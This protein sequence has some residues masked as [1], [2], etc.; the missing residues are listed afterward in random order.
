MPRE[1]VSPVSD[2]VAPRVDAGPRPAANPES[3]VIRS[4][5]NRRLKAFRAALRGSGPAAGEPIAIEGPKLV[6][7]G[8]RAGLELK[9]LLVS[10]TGERYLDRIFAVARETED[11]IPRSRI[12]RTT[13]KLFAGIAGTETPQGI[14]ALFRQR[15]WAFEDV[16]RGA[17]SPDGSFRGD[18]ALVVV[19]VGVQDPGNVGT[20]VRSAEAFGATGVI[21]ARGTADPWSPKA[22][23]ASAASAMRLPLL[24]S[25]A[26][27]VALVQLRTVGLRIYV[28][29]SGKKSN[30]EQRNESARLGA[31]LA[32]ACAIL[33]G[34]EGHGLPSELERSA[35]AA[36]SVPILEQVESLNAA[37]AASV[38]LYE[39]ARQRRDAGHLET[40]HGTISSD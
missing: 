11:G 28:A 30:P 7:D 4:R 37:A 16:L 6:E 27:T 18:P 12:F 14:A 10:E 34:S 39:A 26:P 36:I 40:T 32:E 21:C 17:A 20:I 31:N 22:V 29:V 33:I 19:L 38:L 15:E 9:A 1:G 5:D 8:L 35:D 13:D 3:E 25:L 24:R 23:R 2:T